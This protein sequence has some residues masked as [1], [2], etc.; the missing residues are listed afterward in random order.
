MILIRAYVVDAWLHNPIFALAS[1]KRSLPPLY[2]LRTSH[3][4]HRLY[5]PQSPREAKS[6]VHHLYQSVPPLALRQRRPTTPTPQGVY[7]D[8]C[9]EHPIPSIPTRLAGRN[10]ED[11]DPGRS[12]LSAWI[13]PRDPLC[14]RPV[15]KICL[16]DARLGLCDGRSRGREV[17]RV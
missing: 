3:L 8:L 4:L 13:R 6:H 2:H 15:G 1:T 10:Y 17:K 7:I 5:V 16:K 14:A 11:Q 9:Q 12:I